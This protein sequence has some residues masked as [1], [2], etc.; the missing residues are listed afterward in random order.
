MSD[1]FKTEQERFWHGEFG[2]EYTIRNARSEL[3]QSN[4]ALFKKILACTGKLK[5]LIEF[6]ANIGLNLRAIR[7]LSPD[8]ELA[9]LELNKSAADQLRAW[10]ECKVYEGSLFDFTID[11]QWDMTLAKGVLIHI[12][13]DNLAHAYRQLYERSRRFICI[14][15]YYNPTPISV[16]YRGHTN[17][18]F[19]R[20]FAGEMLDIYPN[21]ALVDYGF[22]YRRDPT[23]PQDD[24]TWF[25]LEKR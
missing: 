9:A 16:V 1:H 5:S 3:I 4:A 13:P 7:Y 20:D 19:K 23:F 18:L 12:N 24:T 8:T 25:I 15:E 6:G 14:S 2:D 21:L 11:T 10:G 22:V 17:K